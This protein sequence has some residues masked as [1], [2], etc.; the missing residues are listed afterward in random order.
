MFAHSQHKIHVH[1]KGDLGYNL[2][3]LILHEIYFAVGFISCGV[4]SHL[5]YYVH[6]V[7][8]LNFNDSEIESSFNSS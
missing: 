5:R 6:H 8:Q 7:L 1:Q 2:N 4:H 3:L